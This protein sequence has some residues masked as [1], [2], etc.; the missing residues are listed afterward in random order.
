MLLYII[1]KKVGEKN[2]LINVSL[3]ILQNKKADWASELTLVF[4]S[5]NRW[6]GDSVW[7]GSIRIK[8]RYDI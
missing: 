8:C 3:S 1:L 6:V 2:M 4:M 7:I 5:I